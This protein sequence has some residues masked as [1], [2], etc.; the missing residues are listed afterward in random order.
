MSPYRL[1]PQ[2]DCLWILRALFM[3]DPDLEA[4][5][6]LV[7]ITAESC[8]SRFQHR[9]SMP[10][11]TKLEW[12]AFCTEKWPMQ[13][14]PCCRIGGYQV[15][16]SS[17]CYRLGFRSNAD[18]STCPRVTSCHDKPHPGQN[19]ILVPEMYAIDTTNN[20]EIGAPHLCMSFIPGR[21]V[22]EVW[23][24][25]TLTRE[26]MCLRILASISKTMAQ[27]SCLTFDNMGSIIEE[28]LAQLSLDLYM[29]GTKL[30]M[31]GLRLPL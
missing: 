9:K 1:R 7:A 13:H 29:T 23:V 14:R 10:T 6:P 25:D 28:D 27:F 8:S 18:R 2:R 11:S 31:A 4:F 5:G 12:K 3:D 17:P 16:G 30:N 24:S 19:K 26:E 20:N 15:R 22:S 21:P